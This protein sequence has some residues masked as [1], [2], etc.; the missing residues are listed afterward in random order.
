MGE[1]DAKTFSNQQ[2]ATNTMS[3]IGP[4]GG[5]QLDIHPARRHFPRPVKLPHDSSNSG[6]HRRTF[7]SEGKLVVG[8]NGVQGESRTLDSSAQVQIA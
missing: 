8:A 6:S 4:T 2:I 7:G 1:C 3:I 5:P